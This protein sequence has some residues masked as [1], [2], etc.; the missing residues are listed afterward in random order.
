MTA[1]PVALITGCGGTVGSV[2]AAAVRARGGTPIAWDRALAPPGDT[3]AARRLVEQHA[4]T[5]LFHTALP[6]RP[7]GAE[8]EGWLVNEKWTADLAAIALQRAIPFVFTSSV[9]VFS[10]RMPGPLTP[11]KEPDETEGYG[12]F[13]RCGELSALA[14]NPDARIARL[15]WQIGAGP[16][17]NNMIDF[18]EKQS[19]DSGAIRASTRWLPG[20]SFLED[21]AEALLEVAALPPGCYHVGGNTRWNFHEIVCA[22]NARHGGR[23]RVEPTEDFVCDQRLL[24]SRLRLR[25]LE[26]RLP[27]LLS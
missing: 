11:D 9:M 16:G 15:G 23:W 13:K 2:L 22:L 12:H 17:S 14:A 1:A 6:S 19:A 8:N 4:P 10:N 20:T 25:P 3:D 26:D 18:L 24:D 5:V 21:T 7:T 27:A